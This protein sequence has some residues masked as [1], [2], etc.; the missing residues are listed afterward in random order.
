MLSL[1]T[2]HQGCQARVA[3]SPPLQWYCSSMGKC[4]GR[5]WAPYQALL[6]T[7]YVQG[8]SGSFGVW[9]SSAV[10]LPR[11]PPPPDH[12]SLPL[13]SSPADR[14]QSRRG[15][16]SGAFRAQCPCS[17]E[18]SGGGVLPVYKTPKDLQGWCLRQ[19]WGEPLRSDCQG[20]ASSTSASWARTILPY[21]RIVGK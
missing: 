16:E 8:C 9:L 13:S 1:G 4:G 6:N 15:Q 17:M 5:L 3:Q 21:P 20:G 7:Y 12:F 14:K 10:T 18:L 2:G 19:A 11:M